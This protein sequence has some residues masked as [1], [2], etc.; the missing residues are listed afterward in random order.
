MQRTNGPSMQN[1]FDKRFAFFGK[2]LDFFNL[3]V[4]IEAEKGG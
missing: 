4:I 1:D 2:S 3:S